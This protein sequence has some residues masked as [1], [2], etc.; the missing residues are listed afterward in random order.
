MALETIVAAIAAEADAEAE[1]ILSEA[2][3]RV[4]SILSEARRRADDEQAHWE[5]SRAEE[6][7]LAVSGIVNRARLEAD[8]Q[9][10]DA[11]EALFQD[12]MRRL[13]DRVR[14][15]VEGPDYPGILRALHTEATVVVPDPDATI[16]VRPADRAIGERIA[17]EREMNGTV[18]GVLDCIGGLDVEAADGRSV[19]NTLDSRLS[20]SERRLRRLAVQLIPEMSSTET[21][22]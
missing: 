13:A 16:L 20:Q 8:R 5:E 18:H 11:R 21:E 6:T 3:E 12:A 10:A 15:V 7:S 14:H 2:A 1:R 22:Q 9:V 17:R 19:R 4:A